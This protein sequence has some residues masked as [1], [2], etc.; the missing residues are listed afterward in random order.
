MPEGGKES[1]L[2]PGFSS[3]WVLLSAEPSGWTRENR[4]RAYFPAIGWGRKY[5]GKR[6]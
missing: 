5:A 1:F 2:S 6:F 4:W 3:G